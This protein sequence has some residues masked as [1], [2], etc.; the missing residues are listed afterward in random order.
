MAA[1]RDA[2]LLALVREL[3][4]QDVD[5]AARIDTVA[6]VARS[7]R[8]DPRRRRRV[9]GALEALP[10]AI[11]VAEQSER[12]ALAREA[13]ARAELER[14]RAAARRDQRRAEGER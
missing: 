12:E 5:V 2:Q 6:G 3:E 4:R 11:A 1:D 14:G 7:R 9:L 10:E 13:E 8:R